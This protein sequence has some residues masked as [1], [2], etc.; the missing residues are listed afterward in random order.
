[1]TELAPDPQAGGRCAGC[2]HSLT[3]HRLSAEG[4]VNRYG[5]RLVCT[6]DNCVWTECRERPTTGGTPR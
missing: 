6:V 5:S 4:R 1:M 2:G 3:R